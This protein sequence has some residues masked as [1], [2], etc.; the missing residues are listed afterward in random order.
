[1]IL[2]ECFRQSSPVIPKYLGMTGVL[3]SKNQEDNAIELVEYSKASN[4]EA[5]R[6][7]THTE[8]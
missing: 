7:Q 6:S 4:E 3:G 1:M 2:E 5:Y 8:F